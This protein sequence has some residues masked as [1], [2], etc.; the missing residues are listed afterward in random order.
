MGGREDPDKKRARDRVYGAKPESRAKRRE[1]LRIAP[2]SEAQRAGDVAR[3]RKHRVVSPEKVSA[4]RKVREA[5]RDGLLVIASACQKC[6]HSPPPG[7]DGRR[8][9]HAHHHNGYDKPLDVEW[10]CAV[11]HAEEHRARGKEQGQ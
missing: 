3:A 5:L 7:R 8:T 9:L 11:C 10:I 1:R 6:S 2:R 4:R